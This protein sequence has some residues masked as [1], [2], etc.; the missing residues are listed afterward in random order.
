MQLND[1]VVLE[2]MDHELN[3]A[4]LKAY[5]KIQ[6]QSDR[7]A[8][9]T[10]KYKLW[11]LFRKAQAENLLNFFDEF[12]KTVAIAQELIDEKTSARIAIHFTLFQGV[13]Q[14]RI[15]ENQLQLTQHKQ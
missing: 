4:P 10:P 5:Q 14:Q 1:S 15:K 12:Q 8:D 7:L 11:W 13:I 3:Q 6:S 2:N 9:M